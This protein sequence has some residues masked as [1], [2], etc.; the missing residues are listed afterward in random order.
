MERTVYLR[1]NDWENPFIQKGEF[2]IKPFGKKK[3]QAIATGANPESEITED[4]LNSK[5]TASEVQATDKK[6]ETDPK[7]RFIRSLGTLFIILGV[8]GLLLPIFNTFLLRQNK[9]GSVQSMSPEQMRANLENATAFPLEE[10][11]ELGYFNFWKWL[12]KSSDENI[13]GELVVPSV[14]IRLPIYNNSSNENLLVGVGLMDP[15]RQMGQG[16]Y[17]LAGHRPSGENLLLHNLMDV[18]MGSTIYLTNHEYTYVYRVA[19]T[20]QTDV[21]AVSML[22]A[23]EVRN[24]GNLPIVSLMTCYNGKSSSRW[25]VVGA[26][27]K[28]LPYQEEQLEK[29]YDPE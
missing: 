23:G 3:D 28:T 4:Q 24:Y 10:I 16:N 22:D 11:Q 18:E 27:E 13:I 15:Q 6:K 12:G 25:F 1:L 9:H 26:Y 7:V 2:M 21:N 17:I 14:S 20:L 29:E 8:L 5:N 19:N